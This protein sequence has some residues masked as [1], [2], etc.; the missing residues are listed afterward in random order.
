MISRGNSRLPSFRIPL[1][2]PNIGDL[3]KQYVLRALESSYVS[4]IGPLVSEF[5]ERF[6]GYVGARYAVAT[7]NG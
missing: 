4:S 3:E 1:D 7:V 2:A 6:A 5:E